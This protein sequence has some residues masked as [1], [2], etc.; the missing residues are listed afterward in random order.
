MKK[1]ILIFYQEWTDIINQLA[2]IDYHL[3]SYD[4]LIV[5]LRSDAEGIYEHYL[6]GKSSVVKKYISGHKNMT[7]LQS[8]LNQ[9]NQTEY[10]YLC[11]GKYDT[12]RNDEYKNVWGQLCRSLPLKEHFNKLLYT[13][14]GIDHKDRVEHFS[15]VRDIELEDTVYNKF[16]TD[17]SNDYILYHDNHLNDSTMSFERKD[18]QTYVNING[19]TDKPFS[20]IKVLMNA[21]EIH[22]VDSFWASVCYHIDARYSLLKDVD[23]FLYPFKG[24]SNRWGGLVKDISYKDELELQPK[25]LQN[26]KIVTNE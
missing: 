2:L 19:I 1:G 25:Q 4:E 6:K 18:D 26:W 20:F 23:I 22:L 5:I 7:M 8:I 10:D 17:N 24:G 14:Y 9:Y 16:I 21:K 12:F 11:Y 13:S 15:F 3:V